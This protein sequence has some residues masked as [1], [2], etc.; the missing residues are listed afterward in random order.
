M[1]T[2]RLRMWLPCQRTRFVLCSMHVNQVRPSPRQVHAVRSRFP[3]CCCVEGCR[4]R[5]DND[6]NER[7]GIDYGRSRDS[8]SQNGI[9]RNHNGRRG[10][11]QYCLCVYSVLGLTDGVMDNKARYDTAGWI[12]GIERF[13]DTHSNRV[14]AVHLLV[15]GI[16]L[17]RRNAER[18]GY[19]G[20]DESG[21]RPTHQIHVPWRCWVEGCQR[22][23]GCEKDHAH[24][25]V[26]RRVVP[27]ISNAGS[28]PAS[29]D[30]CQ[31]ETW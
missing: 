18:G 22:R 30:W 14:L 7:M 8:A 10:A 9:V 26:C 5:G 4:P 2:V 15:G 3:Q 24:P 17:F 20:Q 1:S 19:G 6:Q 21:T 12:L 13:F 16:S 23:G 11:A 25:F 31:E 29:Q 28:L 27:R